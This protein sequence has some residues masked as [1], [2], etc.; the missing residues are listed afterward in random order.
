MRLV[1]HEKRCALLGLRC[2][3]FPLSRVSARSPRSR[4]R[5]PRKQLRRQKVAQVKENAEFLMPF[6]ASFCDHIPTELEMEELSLL[7]CPAALA[8]VQDALTW[9]SQ[10]FSL[11]PQF[12]NEGEHRAPRQ[13]ALLLHLQ[14][15]AWAN[16][17]QGVERSFAA[18]CMLRFQKSSKAR[19][20]PQACESLFPTNILQFIITKMDLAPNTSRHLRC[21]GVGRTT[22]A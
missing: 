12:K 3:L 18:Y 22:K 8:C 16:T 20:R 13:L 6:L 5:R 14:C 10:V 19:L 7:V 15:K 1:S 21:R 2:R 4:R 11:N 17:E 9:A